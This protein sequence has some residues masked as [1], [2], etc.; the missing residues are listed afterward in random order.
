MTRLATT[1]SA[2]PT[3]WLS[4]IVTLGTGSEIAGLL[5]LLAVVVLVFSLATDRFLTVRRLRRW[6]SSCRNSGC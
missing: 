5:M 3:P 6:R 2:S 1:K 4:R